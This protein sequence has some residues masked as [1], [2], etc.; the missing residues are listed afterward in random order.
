MQPPPS[1]STGREVVE[2]AIEA[3]IGL[4]PVVGSPLAVAFAYAVGQPLQR[5]M[6]AWLTE[7]A[8]A[9]DELTARPDGPTLQELIDDERFVDAVI[10]ATRAAQRTHERDKLNA[11]RY[12]VLNST[13]PGAPDTDEQMMFF[14]WVDDYTVSHLR[15]LTYLHDP[16]GWYRSHGLALWIT[17]AG[18]RREAMEAALPELAGRRD[19]TDVLLA[20]LEAAGFLTGSI[21]SAASGQAV[22]NQLT[23]AIAGRFLSF[24]TAPR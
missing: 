10:T 14:R 8:E 13:L 11:L 23:T 5:R 18:S 9:V 20:D 24:I 17:G 4:V 2:K 6:Q 22:Y 19:F 1:K 21:D 12:A 7:L 3:G 15:L 16:S